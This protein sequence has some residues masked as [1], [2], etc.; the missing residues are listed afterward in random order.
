MFSHGTKIIIRKLQTSNERIGDDV[1][2][3]LSA[4]RFGIATCILNMP[5]RSLTITHTHTGLYI[6]SIHAQCYRHPPG[7]CS[8]L[9]FLLHCKL[10]RSQFNV[11]YRLA[12]SCLCNM[13]CS[14]VWVCWLVSSTCF[15]NRALNT[16]STWTWTRKV[17]RKNGHWLLL[18][19]VQWKNLQCADG[20]AE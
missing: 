17:V 10:R 4:V 11:P 14:L 12:M 20:T 15:Y 8:Q 3:P 9:F 19:S 1:S 13:L 18:H 16:F 6:L 7:S 5:I 2:S